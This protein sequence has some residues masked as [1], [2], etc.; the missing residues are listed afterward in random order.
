MIEILSDIQ[1]TIEDEK[2]PLR[3][4]EDELVV[5]MSKFKFNEKISNF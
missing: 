1:E 4:I 3:Q 2:D 5:N